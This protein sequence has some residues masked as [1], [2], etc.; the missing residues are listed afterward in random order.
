MINIKSGKDFR[1][2]VSLLDDNL[3][4]YY[5]GKREYYRLIALHLWTLLC[6]RSK[7]KPLIKRMFPDF[8]LHPLIGSTPEGDQKPQ[9]WQIHDLLGPTGLH[10]PTMVSGTGNGKLTAKIMF[11]EN[12]K[13]I[14]LSKWLSQPLLNQEITIFEFIKTV[15]NKM[16]AHSDPDYNDLLARTESLHIVGIPALEMTT[17]TLGEYILKWIKPLVKY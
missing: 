14:P 3:K 11:E 7:G 8:R 12:R 13:K 5:S 10:F 1:D 9:L 17:V 6:D 15:R 2:S 4:Q 16:S